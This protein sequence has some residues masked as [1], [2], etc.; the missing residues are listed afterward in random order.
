MFCLH[1]FSRSSRASSGINR[2]E[3]LVGDDLRLVDAGDWGADS[4]LGRSSPFD[5]NIQIER[6]QL[7]Q[8]QKPPGL[9]QEALDNLHMEVYSCRVV[10]TEGRVSSSALS[11]CSIC[12]ESFMEN[13]VLVSLP[14]GHQFHSSCLNPWVRTC[15]DCPYCRR[16]ILLG[17]EVH[18][19]KIN[20][21]SY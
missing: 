14:C 11:D 1:L 16:A 3:S 19:Y 20:T 4:F 9:S 7:L 17:N 13:D 5:F 8:Q 10:D 6:P 2:R 21:I 12:L 15:G 18:T